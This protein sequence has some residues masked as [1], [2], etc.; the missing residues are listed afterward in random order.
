MLVLDGSG[1]MSASDFP[2]GAPNR[3]DRVRQALARVIPEVAP[4]RRIGLLVYGPGRQ[5]NSCR[6]IEVKLSPSPG[7]AQAILDFAD[8][9]RPGG[10]TPLTR[11]VE[12]ALEVLNG[13]T[14]PA[15]VVVLTDGEDTC[16]GDPCG[17]A[18]RLKAQGR[19]ITIHVVGF[20]LPRTSETAGARCLADETGGRFVTAETTDELVQALRQTLT[21]SQISSPWPVE[22]VEPV[23]PGAR[24]LAQVQEVAACRR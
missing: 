20:R 14:Q 17:F 8:R 11:S 18:R 6:N 23:E 9:V 10:R 5:G 16:G 24:R 7:A 2:D 1:S 12:I 19:D 3:M 4:V 13:S 21:C 22:P 15:E